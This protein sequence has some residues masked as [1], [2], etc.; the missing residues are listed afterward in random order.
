M[1]TSLGRLTLEKIKALT[2]NSTL[3]QTAK[4][5]D[6]SAI[7][8]ASKLY[9]NSA[10]AQAS[11][12]YENSAM[13]QASKLYEISAMA[14]ASK[15][16]EISAMAQASMLYEN[17]AIAQ[18]AARSIAL[19][20]PIKELLNTQEFSSLKNLLHKTEIDIINFWKEQNTQYQLAT[21]IGSHSNLSSIVGSLS[22]AYIEQFAEKNRYFD[23]IEEEVSFNDTAI[24]PI[25]QN[26][27]ATL[28]N[29]TIILLVSV[30]LPIFLGLITNY[31][32][33][34]YLQPLAQE[35]HS[36]K[37]EK[38]VKNHIKTHTHFDKSLLTSYRITSKPLALYT[39]SNLKSPI[40]E[41]IS[42]F[43]LIQRVEESNLHKS[44]LK[45]RVEIN[46]EIVEGYVLRRYTSPIK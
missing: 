13:A 37:S 6:N 7:A 10:M 1:K 36:A 19:S 27:R 40:L 2:E 20:T 41:H 24:I 16:Y 46:G 25:S 35:H 5:S 34:F 17:S 29:F 31:I 12:L 38:E 39:S 30:I 33:E 42:S 44:W 43:T 32:Y 28:N 8:Q 4:F 23:L 14:Q 9:E 11:K 3:A 45:V 26:N 21:L 18:A 15:V 22:D